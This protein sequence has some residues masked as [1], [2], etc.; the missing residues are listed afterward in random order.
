[1]DL[2]PTKPCIQ[3]AVDAFPAEKMLD[4]A[5]DHSPPYCAGFKS[6]QC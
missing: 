1:M 3:C 4:C 2:G 5:V 6:E